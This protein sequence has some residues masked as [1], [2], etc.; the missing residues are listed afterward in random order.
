[1]TENLVRLHKYLS[2][3]GVCS[4]RKAEAYIE[5]R[6]V[7]VNGKL[8]QELGYKI[9]PEVDIVRLNGKE[10]KNNNTKIY[11]MLNKPRGCLSTVSDPEG[12]PTVME[13]VK[14]IQER[15]FPIGRLDFNTE[16]LLLFT[17]D[18]DFAYRILHPK[19][20]LKKIYLVSTHIMPN[21]DQIAILESGILLEGKKLAKCKIEIVKKSEYPNTM[22]ITI[23]EGWNRQIRKMFNSISCEVIKLTRIQIGGL[24]LGNIKLGTFRFLQKN[25]LEAIFE[26]PLK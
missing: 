9:N 11:I 2:D 21:L 10:I 18:G 15:I 5:Q 12:R 20:V 13:Y 17:N 1:M 14:K 6:L 26:D 19:F 8:I 16:G 24:P 4:R 3:A 25:D 7:T 22:K 23:H